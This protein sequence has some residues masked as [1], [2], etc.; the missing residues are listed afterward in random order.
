MGTGT[1]AD[2]YCTIEAATDAAQP[3]DTVLLAEDGTYPATT[4][5]ASGAAGAPITISGTG[6]S[7]PQLSFQGVHDVVLQGLQVAMSTGSLQIEDSSDLTLDGLTAAPPPRAPRP[8][9]DPSSYR[10]APRASSTPVRA[11]AH[12]RPGQRRVVWSGSG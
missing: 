12:P 9:S 4:I 3:G 11:W 8:P 10:S 1:V 5:T 7:L 2:P 6:I